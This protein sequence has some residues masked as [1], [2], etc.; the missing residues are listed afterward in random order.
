MLEQPCTGH[1]Y[2]T[3]FI[4][5]KLSNSQDRTRFKDVFRCQM[6]ISE[7][8]L[9]NLG[10]SWKTSELIFSTPTLP[11]FMFCLNRRIKGAV[12]FNWA[13]EL[14]T[15]TCRSWALQTLPKSFWTPESWTHETLMTFYSRFKC[16][17]TRQT[18]RQRRKTARSCIL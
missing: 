9:K 17:W 13:S 16:R 5:A 14:I 3:V 8:K 11:W 4:D 12:F 2:K 10:F 7:E 18:C 15:P 6:K 1:M